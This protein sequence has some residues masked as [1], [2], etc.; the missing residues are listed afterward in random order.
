MRVRVR[1]VTAWNMIDMIDMIDV[2][3]IMHHI[4]VFTLPHI[5]DKKTER[6]KDKRHTS[7]KL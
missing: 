3:G 7:Y 2:A 4:T 6:Q 5:P 1:I